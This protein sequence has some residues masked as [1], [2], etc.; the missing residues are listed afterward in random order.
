MIVALI[1]SMLLVLN[2]VR[3]ALE[4]ACPGCAA[5]SWAAHSTQLECADCGWSHGR[6]TAAAPEP[7]QYE[8]CL[9]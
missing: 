8:I 7:A 4:P 5:K 6:A 9:G 3:R 1:L 2:V